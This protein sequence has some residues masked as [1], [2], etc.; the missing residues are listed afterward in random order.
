MASRVG[1]DRA[2]YSIVRHGTGGIRGAPRPVCGPLTGGGASLVSRLVW[3]AGGMRA[4]GCSRW[5]KPGRTQLVRPR[6][7]SQLVS[8]KALGE[9]HSR[10]TT[11]IGTPQTGHK[12]T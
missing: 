11:R 12:A 4:H 2:P 3:P 1:G 6:P 10:L 5:G 9:V 7:G 8:T